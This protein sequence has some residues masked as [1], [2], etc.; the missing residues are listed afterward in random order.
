MNPCGFLA[1]L[2]WCVLLTISPL[3]RAETIFRC[4]NTYSQ[5]PC[6]GATQM[7]IDDARDP[8]RKKEVDAATRRDASL[9]K[10]LEQERLQTEKAANRQVDSKN[11]AS[12]ATGDKTSTSAT[13]APPTILTPKRPRK[14]G[15]KPKG[16]TAFVP[17][18][19]VKA[20]AH[21]KAVKKHTATSE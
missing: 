21:K 7:T 15:Y 17:G 5:T 13:E 10:T 2:L 6:A 8:S 3:G 11:K 19:D 20:P 9:A 16:F 14:A 4:G 12:V 18:S 1:S